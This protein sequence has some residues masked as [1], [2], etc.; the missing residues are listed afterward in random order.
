VPTRFED[1]RDRYA[2]FRLERTANGILT[3]AHHTDGGPHVHTGEAHTE[4]AEVFHD[5]GRDPDN[6]VVIWTGTGGTWIDACGA[7]P[8]P[9]A[10]VH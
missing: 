3:V 2:H 7:A 6:E 1:Y 8:C 10:A 5:I 4:F 9:R